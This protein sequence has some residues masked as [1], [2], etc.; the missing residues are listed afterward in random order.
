M[1]GAEKFRPTPPV[2][3]GVALKAGATLPPPAPAITV[4]KLDE[5]ADFIINPKPTSAVATIAAAVKLIVV[6]AYLFARWRLIDDAAARAAAQ[7]AYEKSQDADASKEVAAEDD[8][9]GKTP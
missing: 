1:R 5:M 6:C 2:K 7:Q 3:P 4:A 8:L 9:T